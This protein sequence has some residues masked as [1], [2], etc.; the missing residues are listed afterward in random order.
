M[1]DTVDEL[2]ELDA[3]LDG[4]DL[5]LEPIPP[6]IKH[7][8]AHAELSTAFSHIDFR[9]IQSLSTCGLFLTGFLSA[10]RF[11]GATPMSGTIGLVFKKYMYFCSA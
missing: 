4:L 7:L 10:E 2:E 6:H 1:E 8:I 3:E 9:T 5:Q 11:G